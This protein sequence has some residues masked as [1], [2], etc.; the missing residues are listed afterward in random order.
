MREDYFDQLTF[1]QTLFLWYLRIALA[2]FLYVLAEK[3]LVLI[4]DD[5]LRMIF[6]IASW[7]GI[8]SEMLLKLKIK[9]LLLSLTV[10]M[11][12]YGLSKIK[13]I[14]S[15]IKGAILWVQK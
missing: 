14:S 5:N 13:Y 3:V 11:G 6:Q 1:R 12:L 8:L 2:C 15:N 9:D 4:T 7:L 10:I